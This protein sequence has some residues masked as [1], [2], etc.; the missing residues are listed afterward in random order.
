L[1]PLLPAP[2]PLTLAFCTQ[3]QEDNLTPQMNVVETC[4]LYCA[5][6]LPRGTPVPDAAARIDE[7]LRAM[8]MS[9]ARDRLV[10]GVLPGGLLLRGLSGGERKRLWVAVGILA[11]PSIVFLDGAWPA[12]R[13]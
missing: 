4:Q 9:H 8:G 12:G 5:L 11:T 2:G 10:G 3:H 7:V 6:T 13:G 1:T